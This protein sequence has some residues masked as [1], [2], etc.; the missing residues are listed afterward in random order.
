MFLLRVKLYFTAN[1]GASFIMGFILFLIIEAIFQSIGSTTF[2]D[3]VAAFAC[4]SLIIGIV[5]QLVCFLKDSRV[6]VSVTGSTT[7][8]GK[9]NTGTRE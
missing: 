4:Y 6:K 3:S 1:W 7:C 2:A 9:E 8:K 5:L